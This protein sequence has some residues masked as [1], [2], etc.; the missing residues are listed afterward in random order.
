VIAV[1]DVVVALDP[2]K[3]VPPRLVR[4]IPGRVWIVRSV[5]S[6]NDSAT[7][8]S[9][10]VARRPI[11]GQHCFSVRVGNSDRCDCRV[12]VEITPGGGRRVTSRGGEGLDD[13]LCAV[14][15]TRNPD[16]ARVQVV[17][18]A[19]LDPAVDVWTYG[20]VVLKTHQRG[21]GARR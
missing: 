15:A 14:T 18:V 19:L 10:Q 8:L 16:L 11:S 2:K 17:T 1:G 9:T 3:C 4:S 13:Q 5:G 7:A 20:D 6:P 21:S 12:A